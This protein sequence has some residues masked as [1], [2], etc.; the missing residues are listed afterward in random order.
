MEKFIKSGNLEIWTESFGDPKNPAL[1]LI[2]GVAGQGILWTDDFCQNLAKNFFVIRY[3]HRDVGLS[4]HL[5][6][7]MQPYS[8]K[9]LANDIVSIIN[10]Y[11]ISST[12]LL[13]SSMGGYLAQ[14]CMQKNPEK[15]KSATLLMSTVDFSSI[16]KSAAGTLAANDLPPPEKNVLEGLKTIGVIDASNFDDWLLKSLQVLKLFNGTKAEFNEAEWAP[17]LEKSY[18]RRNKNVINPA[19]HNHVMACAQGPVSFY[20]IKATC[21][22]HIIHGSADPMIPVAHAH[23]TG[24]HYNAKLSIIE[25]MGHLRPKAFKDILVRTITDFCAAN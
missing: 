8:L 11:S 2:M 12:H 22:V 7:M 24:K 3:D 16:G 1:I 23:K 25:N 13:G 19:I 10:E 17:I 5:N 6:Y 15:L 4:T 14:I 9:D 18:L 20:D 21:P